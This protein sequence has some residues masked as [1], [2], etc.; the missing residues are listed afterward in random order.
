MPSTA[1]N[2]RERETEER[3]TL[4]VNSVSGLDA[5]G[6]WE[7]RISLTDFVVCS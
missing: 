7:L 1:R 4:E 3:Y 2:E 6:R 5:S